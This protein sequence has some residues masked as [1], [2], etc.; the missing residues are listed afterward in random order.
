MSDPFPDE[1]DPQDWEEAR[2]R[3]DAIREHLRRRPN[4]S[5]TEEIL[6]LATVLG[7]IQAT[8]YRLVRLFREGD[9]KINWV[10]C[11]FQQ[12][13]GGLEHPGKV[14][15]MRWFWRLP[16]QTFAQVAVEDRRAN[17]QHAMRPFEGPL[18]LLLFDH[19]SGDKG[20]DG[21]LSE[22]RSDPAPGSIS[23]TVIDNRRLVL[24]DVGQESLPQL[25]Y[26]P[27]AHVALFA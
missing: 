23:S 12:W 8:A 25:P 6:E 2:R 16:S 26:A 19:A 10:S 17:L 4:R 11:G 9:R 14:M 5:T 7:V 21:G 15:P 24:T 22:R 1:V 13:R 3:A 18:H 20:I 27:G